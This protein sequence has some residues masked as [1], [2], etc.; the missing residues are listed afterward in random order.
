MIE[1]VHIPVL[2]DEPEK[3]RITDAAYD[4]VSSQ[5]MMIAPGGRKLVRTNTAVSIPEGYVGL[6]CSRSGLALKH[7]VFVLNAPGVIDPDYTDPIGVI[8]ANFGDEIYSVQKGDRIAQL[9]IVKTADS[10]FLPVAALDGGF[11]RGGNGF[12]SSGR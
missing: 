7:G 9:F 1:D 12:G 6:V 2:G 8:L 11:T 4:L 5:D 3:G 10:L